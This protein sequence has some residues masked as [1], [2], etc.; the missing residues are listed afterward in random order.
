MVMCNVHHVYECIIPDTFK[1]SGFFL[2]FLAIP[3]RMVYWLRQWTFLQN[4]F[5]NI[6]VKLWI[7]VLAET[8]IDA[9]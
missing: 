2:K 6:K 4:P 7:K 9:L 1:C 3:D 8:E 5:L